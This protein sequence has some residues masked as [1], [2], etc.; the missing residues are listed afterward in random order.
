MYQFIIDLSIHTFLFISHVHLFKYAKIEY[1]SDTLGYTR[2]GL[3]DL[4]KNTFVF[5]T[6]SI[7]ECIDKLFSYLKRT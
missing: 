1:S 6:L 7:G 3:G 2:I 5:S 4:N